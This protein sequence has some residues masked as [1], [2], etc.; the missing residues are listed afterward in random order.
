MTSRVVNAFFALAL[1]TPAWLHAQAPPWL[2]ARTGGGPSATDNCRGAACDAAGVTYITGDFTGT[3]CLLGGTLYNSASVAAD[4]Y[5]IRYLADGSPAWVRV[6]GGAGSESGVDI[7][8]DSTGAAI[9]TG[10]HGTPVLNCGTNPSG[11]TVTVTTSV[12]TRGVLVMKLNA[13]GQ[14]EWASGF[15]GTGTAAGNEV[16]TGPSDEI[17]VTGP[18]A[19]NGGTTLTLPNSA[20]LTKVGGD[21]D[22]FVAK[23]NA[24]G[25]FQWGFGLN[26]DGHEEGRGISA[27]AAGNVLVCGEF[28]GNL[29]LGT[30]AHQ[31]A[32]LS[33][34]FVA[35]YDASGAFL[36]SR[37]FGGT[38]A[39]AGRG[40]DPAPDG[41]V[42]VSGE[43]TGAVTFDSFTLTAAGTTKDLFLIKLDTNGVV[44]WARSFGSASSDSGCEIESD[45]AGNIYCAGSAATGLTFPGGVTLGSAGG[46]D[47]FVAKF[48]PNG[49]LLWAR[50]GGGPGTDLNFAL[51]LDPHGRV[52]VV[53]FYS[54]SATYGP[55]TITA[56]GTSID[57]YAARLETDTAPPQPPVA[58]FTASTTNGFAP[59]AV[60]FTDQTGR[61]AP[62]SWAWDF[63]DNG[64]TDSTAQNP[65]FTY[66]LAGTYS[67]KLTVSNAQGTNAL[68]RTNYI[69]VTNDPNALVADFTAGVTSGF[70]PLTFTFTDQ[71]TGGPTLWEWDFQNDLTTDSTAQNPT[72]TFTQVGTYSVK[73][74]VRKTGAVNSLVKTLYIDVSDPD[75]ATLYPEQTI[76]VAGQTRSYHIHVPASYAASAPVPLV[77]DLHGGGGRGDFIAEDHG[78]LPLSDQHGF[79]VVFPNGGELFGPYGGYDWNNYWQQPT[80]DDSAYLAALISHLRASYNID[81]TRV[82]MTGHSDGAAMCNTFATFYGDQLAAAAPVNGNWLTTFGLPETLLA[83]LAPIPVWTW[84]G[85]TEY[86]LT[87][88]ETRD[89]QDAKQKA[90]WMSALGAG[91]VQPPVG[92]TDGTYSYLD[93]IYANGAAEYRFTVELG[94]NHAYR[95][96]YAARIW[97][98]FFSRKTRNPASRVSA[99]TQPRTSPLG[100]A[101]VTYPPAAD[102]P[103]HFYGWTAAG[104]GSLITM[105]SSPDLVAWTPFAIAGI[106]GSHR[107]MFMRDHGAAAPGR[108]FYRAQVS[109]APAIEPLDVGIVAGATQVFTVANGVPVDWS[110]AEPGGG[111]I[112][113][114]GIYTAPADA[115]TFHVRAAAQSNPGLVAEARVNIVTVGAEELARFAAAADYSDA[116]DGDALLIMKGGAIVFERYTGTTTATSQHQLASGTKSFGAALFA[117]GEADGIWTLDE[118][119]SQTITE[120]QGVTNKSL[121]TIRQLIS[122]TSGLVD[123][124]EYSATNAQN[125]DTYDLA[126]NDSTTP[127]AP[128]EACIYAPGN[129]QV[130]A[131][132][133]ERKTGMDPAQY[134]YDRLLARLGFSAA[135]LALWTRDLMGKPQMAGGAR[136]TARA[137]ANYGKLWLQN[138]QWEGQTILDPQ[139]MSLAVTYENP[140]FLGYGLTW[141]LNRPNQG[142]YTPGVDNLPADGTGD[143]T[144]IATN[145]PADMFMAAGTGKQRLYVIPSLDLVIVRF[146]HGTGGSFTDHALLG[147]IL[148]VP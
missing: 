141:W 112:T 76:T 113:A 88:I 9:L 117:L 138:G 106:E 86:Q 42:Y 38:G 146:G 16:S 53:G 78:W 32:G 92:S 33:D 62:T 43:F 13:A 39:D 44:Q 50:N 22:V 45:A 130:L 105:E 85:E 97:N 74:T 145:A 24:A 71:S 99:P 59:L 104:D 110:V 102:K 3:N 14:T 12:G 26:G 31:T 48:H 1:L 128:G 127:Y 79:I 15:S 123:S 17:L 72:F 136:F 109:P 25:A 98:E 111:G 5:V 35:K 20:T 28:D 49:T 18:F 95:P 54:G 133:F 37:K 47:Q 36:W 125:L 143:G 131:A 10:T 46:S 6:F 61:G 19:Q 147:E 41:G 140:A 114:E 58:N 119:V 100:L 69:T 66:T 51:G 30:N 56:S 118:N 80:P 120:W 57:F 103:W 122:L 7:D 8:T 63:D 90:W 144:Q 11:Q 142:T 64:T 115:G 148:G 70:V 34:I 29:T 2:W 126:I 65:A 87:G 91:P 124:P 101:R 73:L 77:L 75:E 81:D 60:T 40:I 116:V 137:W 55:E 108:F 107:A 52:T 121:I 83:P 27:D 139:T 132:M 84:R 93:E 129:F 21:Q 68:T 96:E 82:Y 134:L 67:V 4:A 23:F 89:V 135:H 94:Q